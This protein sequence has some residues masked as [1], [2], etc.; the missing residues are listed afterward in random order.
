MFQG[1]QVQQIQKRKASQ[2]DFFFKFTFEKT[3]RD[4]AYSTEG[5]R[6]IIIHPPEQYVLHKSNILERKKQSLSS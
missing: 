6:F 3:S 4:S 1:S 5:G 2:M